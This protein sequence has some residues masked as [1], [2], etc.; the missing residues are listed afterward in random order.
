[1]AGGWLGLSCYRSRDDH[2][3]WLMW[4][5]CDGHVIWSYGGHV[6]GV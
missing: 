5:L 3:I 1:M 2:V 4:C 6:V